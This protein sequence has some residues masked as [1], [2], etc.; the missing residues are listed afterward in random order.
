MHEEG[1][2]AITTIGL[3]A[4]KIQ[5]VLAPTEK[6]KQLPEETSKLEEHPAGHLHTCYVLTTSLFVDI[7]HFHCVLMTCDMS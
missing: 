1:I 2:K 6:S 3:A 5:E 4:T 7:F